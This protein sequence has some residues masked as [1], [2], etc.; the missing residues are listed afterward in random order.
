M[1]PLYI[2][3]LDHPEVLNF[4]NP[5][6]YIWLRMDLTLLYC[7]CEKKARYC[8]N[9]YDKP[10]KIY[11]LECKHCGGRIAISPQTLRKLGFL[12][13]TKIQIELS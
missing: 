10:R 8:L 4:T 2:M 7:E 6:R 11:V 13:L 3:E 1:K 12:P 9:W 5:E